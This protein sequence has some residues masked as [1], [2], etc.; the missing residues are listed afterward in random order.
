MEYWR[1]TRH[2]SNAEPCN[3]TLQA[4][5]FGSS[6]EKTE[7]IS[8]PTAPEP[9][10]PE[11]APEHVP[12]PGQ[13]MSDDPSPAGEKADVKPKVKGHGRNPRAFHPD[14]RFVYIPAGVRWLEL[15]ANSMI[16]FRRIGLHPS[17]EGAR[18]HLQSPFGHHFL[19]IPVTQGV[20][21][22]PPDAKQNH[23]WSIVTAF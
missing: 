20:S 8:P 12:P 10:A 18:I 21:Q 3:R 1:G 11:D 7:N 9:S 4:M 14:V 19:Q 5:L 2:D 23:R 16:K 6:S 15:L 22:V 13:E 17:I